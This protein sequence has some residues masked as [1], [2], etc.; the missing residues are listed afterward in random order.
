VCVSLNKFNFF[1]SD[2]TKIGISWQIFA[3][4]PNT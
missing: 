4:F 1:K 2:L 3:K